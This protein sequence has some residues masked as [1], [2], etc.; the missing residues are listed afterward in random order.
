MTF[1]RCP[2]AGGPGQGRK[3]LAA[4]DFGPPASA[5]FAAVLALT[6]AP[7]EAALLAVPLPPWASLHAEPR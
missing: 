4:K 5:A 6:T 3:A 7:G 2:R 1:P